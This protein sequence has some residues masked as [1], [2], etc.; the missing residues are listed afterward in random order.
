MKRLLL[1]FLTFV[2]LLLYPAATYA[3]TLSVVP[4]TGSLNRGCSYDIRIELDTQGAQTDG[5]DVILQYS[6]TS[7]TIAQNNITNGEIYADYPGNSVDAQAGK[8]SISG[9]SSVS[10]AFSG[11]GIFATLRFAVSNTATGSATL[12]FDFDAN[13][14]TKTTDTNVVERGTI[15]DVLSQ[16]T[17]GNYTIGV[18]ACGAIGTG[19]ASPAGKLPAGSVSTLPLG[20]GAPGASASALPFSQLPSSGLFDNTLILASVGIMLVMMGVLGLAVLK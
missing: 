2:L 18:G 12:K 9:I 13:N 17:D 16:V 6:P 5:T 15:A 11:K 14:K 7:F 19:T 3:A 1:G 8:V 10:D 20:Q 4:P